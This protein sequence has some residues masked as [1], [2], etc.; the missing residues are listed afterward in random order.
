MA[1]KIKEINFEKITI[2]LTCTA[3][4]ISFWQTQISIIKDQSDIKERVK[5]L[6]VIIKIKSENN[7]NG[8]D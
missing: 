1:K 3:I 8:K 4:L 7:K 5:S 6:E 2:L